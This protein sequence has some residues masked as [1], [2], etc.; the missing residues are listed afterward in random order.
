MAGYVAQ[1]VRAESPVHRDEVVQRITEGAWLKR[2]GSRIQGA[3]DDGIQSALRAGKIK[4]R[5]EFLWDPEQQTAPVRDR[6]N[7]ENAQK[8]FELVAPEEIAAAILSEVKRSF[9]MS[10]SEAIGAAGRALGFQRVSSQASESIQRELDN[11]IRAGKLLMDS[12]LVRAA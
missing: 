3:V 7:L 2:A 10:P 12:N 9:S 4:R 8:K 11:L 1:V 6:S 5:G